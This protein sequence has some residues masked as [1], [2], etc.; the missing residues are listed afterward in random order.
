MRDDIFYFILPD[1][2]HRTARAISQIPPL[3]ACGTQ[4]GVKPQVILILRVI[5]CK[6]LPRPPS[7]KKR[8][9]DLQLERSLCQNKSG[10]TADGRE[11]GSW[12]ELIG[13]TRRVRAIFYFLTFPGWL[14]RPLSSVSIADQV[15]SCVQARSQSQSKWSQHTICLY[16]VPDPTPCLFIFTLR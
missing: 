12:A 10:S 4:D 7:P 9:R 16:N 6:L 5:P 14:W 2:I 3:T 15:H 1:G 11:K 8:E 13:G